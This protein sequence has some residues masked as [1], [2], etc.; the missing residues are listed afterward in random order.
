MTLNTFHLA[1]HGAANVTLGIPRLRE[2]VMT[3][4]AHIATPTMK[5]PF[6]E[7]KTEADQ[8]RFVQKASRLTIS[9]IIDQVLVEERLLPKTE[10]ARKRKYQVKLQFYDPKEYTETY[11]VEVEEVLNG[12]VTNFIPSLEKAIKDELKRS[13]RQEK[14]QAADIGRGHAARM[15]EAQ[16]EEEGQEDEILRHDNIED[17]EDGDADDLKRAQQQNQNHDYDASDAGS[18]AGRDPEDEFEAAFASAGGSK[19]PGD[20]QSG[21]ESEDEG[22]EPSDARDKHAQLQERMDK[23]ETQGS[24]ASHFVTNFKFDKQQGAWCNFDVQVR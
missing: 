24:K 19:T 4:S 18:D 15:A 12:I 21:S 13:S 9:E 10:G 7:D 17:M 1:G 8:R 16:N 2:I 22:D 20:A 11:G 5:I 14:A 3:A 6:L 23:L